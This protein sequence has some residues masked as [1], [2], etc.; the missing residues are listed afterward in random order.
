[1]WP[2]P[3]AYEIRL[4]GHNSNSTLLRIIERR[5]DTLSLEMQQMINPTGPD[6]YTII[7]IQ[8]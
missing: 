2:Y 4:F 3:D 5:N 8:H 7:L 1:M 6:R